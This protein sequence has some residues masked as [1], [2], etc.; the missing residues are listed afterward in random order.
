MPVF[1]S[2]LNGRVESKEKID[3]MEQH[4]NTNSLGPGL[5][6]EGDVLPQ[7]LL[8]T[9]IVQRN[10][11]KIYWQ[12]EV[13]ED[14]WEEKTVVV[15]PVRIMKGMVLVVV[16]KEHV[17]GKDTTLF[18]SFCW[19][20]S[21]IGKYKGVISKLGRLVDFFTHDIQVHEVKQNQNT[22]RGHELE[23]EFA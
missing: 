14:L 2:P 8:N 18:Y 6:L 4:D 9:N 12:K 23:K 17:D 7:R 22:C 16:G 19:F 3:E 13:V 11:D 10:E 20:H 1:D 5:V 15:G 21:W